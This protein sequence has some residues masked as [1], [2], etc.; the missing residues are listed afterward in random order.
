M[1]ICAQS[2]LNHTTSQKSQTG[3]LILWK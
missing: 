3:G 1:D 2:A